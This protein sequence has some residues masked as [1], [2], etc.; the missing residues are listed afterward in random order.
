MS[1]YTLS[2][3]HSYSRRKMGRKKFYTN[4]VS[5]LA[6]GEAFA[7]HSI[8]RKVEMSEMFT[9][10]YLMDSWDLCKLTGAELRVILGL[11]KWVEYEINQIYL[12][13]EKR[14]ALLQITGLKEQSIKNALSSLVKKNILIKRG[15][16][17]YL[18]NPI[19]SFFGSEK[20]RKELLQLTKGTL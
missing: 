15:T 5:D 19:Y 2:P 6:T 14:A 12:S 1:V 18:V 20:K 10:I 4:T 8:G 7:I 16:N 9:R 3:A 11:L 13:Q 17:S